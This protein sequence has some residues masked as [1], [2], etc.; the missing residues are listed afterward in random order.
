MRN[1]DIADTRDKLGIYAQ[2][3]LLRRVGPQLRPD[4]VAGRLSH[5]TRR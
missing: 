5:G 3:G 1:L 2:T 4:R